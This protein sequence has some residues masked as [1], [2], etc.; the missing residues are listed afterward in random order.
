[1]A[2]HRDYQRAKV[3]KAEDLVKVGSIKFKSLAETQEFVNSIV[4]S[5]WYKNRF[6]RW[7]RVKVEDGRKVA[8]G[9]PTEGFIHAPKWARTNLFIL[10][11]FAHVIG[12]MDV[13]DHGKEFCALYLLLVKR[14]IG[15]DCAKELKEKFKEFGVEYR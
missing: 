15:P 2:K 14:W 12:R 8:Y 3:Y 5:C 10:H 4:K 11:E 13:P 1:M 7:S 9:F 6:F